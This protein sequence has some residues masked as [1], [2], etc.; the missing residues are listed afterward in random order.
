[1]IYLQNFKK[2]FELRRYEDIKQDLFFLHYMITLYVNSVGHC[3]KCEKFDTKVSV[4]IYPCYK[5]IFL[6]YAKKYA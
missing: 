5:W 4:R 2:F 3:Y 1:M 6:L